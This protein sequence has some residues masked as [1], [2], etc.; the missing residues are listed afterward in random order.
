MISHYFKVQY[1][2]HKRTENSHGVD[3]NKSY[4]IIYLNILRPISTYSIIL[5]RGLTKKSNIQAV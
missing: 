4:K 1:V 5:L 2:A 3:I